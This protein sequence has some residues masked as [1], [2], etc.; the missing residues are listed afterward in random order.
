[1]LNSIDSAKFETENL[2]PNLMFSFKFETSFS[3]SKSQMKPKASN[4]HVTFKVVIGNRIFC[5]LKILN[6]SILSII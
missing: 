6:P 5:N 1:M 3:D 4:L 2:L